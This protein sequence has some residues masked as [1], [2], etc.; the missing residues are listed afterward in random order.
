M[1]V[2]RLRILSVGAHPHDLMH[3]AGTC[4]VHT[5]LGDTVTWVS[6]TNGA[7]THNEDLADELLKPPAQRDPAIVNQTQEQLSLIHI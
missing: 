1:E 2:Q 4:G 5:R 7:F 6:V 3:A